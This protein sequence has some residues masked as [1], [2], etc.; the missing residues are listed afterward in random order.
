LNC[1]S[2]RP[3]TECMR[4]YSRPQN[5]LEIGRPVTSGSTEGVRELGESWSDQAPEEIAPLL[6]RNDREGARAERSWPRYTD[7]AAAAIAEQ[8]DEPRRWVEALVRHEAAADLVAPF[9]WRAIQEGH[10]GAE[11]VWKQLFDAGYQ[12][13]CR[14]I[15]LMGGRIQAKKVMMVPGEPRPKLPSWLESR[16]E[17]I[18][19]RL[20]EL[21]IPALHR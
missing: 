8:T 5:T 12:H 4:C 10:E 20:P 18:E 21:R 6:V 13:L 7:V 15:A 2:R 9:L 3:S 16:R 14:H 17:R 1:G 11:S 19:A